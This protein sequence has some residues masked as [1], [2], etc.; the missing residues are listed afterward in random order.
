VPEQELLIDQALLLQAL[1]DGVRQ[2][3]VN[4]PCNLNDEARTYWGRLLALPR[5]PRPSHCVG[6]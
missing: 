1:A 5:H 3:P 4:Q 6:L 2:E